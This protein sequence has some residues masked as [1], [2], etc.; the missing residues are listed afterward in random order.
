MQNG[1]VASF[2]STSENKKLKNGMEIVID[3]TL[4]TIIRKPYAFVFTGVFVRSPKVDER[5]LQRFMDSLVIK[6]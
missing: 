1:R 2:T 5:D 6:D 3:K 4:Y